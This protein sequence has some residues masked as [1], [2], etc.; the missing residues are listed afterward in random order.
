MHAYWVTFRLA[1]TGEYAD[2]HARLVA[3]VKRKSVGLVWAQPTSFMLFQS[4]LKIDDLA[5]HLK[6]AINPL[7]DLVLLGM[8]DKKAAR[9]IGVSDDHSIYA[10][11][12]HVQDV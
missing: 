1:D 7:K 5:Q 3:S 9:L 11:L 2:R 8:P 6:S 10:F 12:P 4:D